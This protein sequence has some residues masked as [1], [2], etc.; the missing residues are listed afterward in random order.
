MSN[1]NTYCTL[2]AVGNF[3]QCHDIGFNQTDITWSPC[4]LGICNFKTSSMSS[5]YMHVRTAIFCR[6]HRKWQKWFL[7][8]FLNVYSLK[9]N[10]GFFKLDKLKFFEYTLPRFAVFTYT[11]RCLLKWVKYRLRNECP[12]ERVFI[13]YFIV[14]LASK[15]LKHEQFIYNNWFRSWD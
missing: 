2:F 14:L 9:F 15:K 10:P 1:E 11:F 5:S 13:N 8:H 7:R 4:Q 3:L 6:I 12:K